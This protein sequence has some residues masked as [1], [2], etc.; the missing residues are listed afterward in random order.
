PGRD[1]RVAGQV[2]RRAGELSLR[3]GGNMLR[4]SCF[5]SIGIAL[6]IFTSSA[7][8]LAAPQPEP[9]RPSWSTDVN[10]SPDGRYLIAYG[11]VKDLRTGTTADLKAL[12]LAFTADGK[13]LYGMFQDQTL[14]C[15]D[16]P[17]FKERFSMKADHGPDFHNKAGFYR[18]GIVVSP[19]GS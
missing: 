16:V 12:R 15:W 13:R 11:T 10:F 8:V 9:A 14:K 17:G 5:Q 19:D 6:L 4:H 3:R 7:D 2:T 18:Y 1:V